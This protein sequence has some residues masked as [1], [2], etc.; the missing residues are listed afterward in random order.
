MASQG[1]FVVVYSAVWLRA[2][3]ALNGQQLWLVFLTHGFLSVVLFVS[4][5]KCSHS[6]VC[7]PS[8]DSCA[9]LSP[10]A[11][12]PLGEFCKPRPRVLCLACPT[13]ILLLSRQQKVLFTTHQI[14]IP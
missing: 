2:H 14:P 7:E 1:S 10:Q 12:A 13:G 9:F 6:T 5:R 8:V 11:K 4:L 3:R